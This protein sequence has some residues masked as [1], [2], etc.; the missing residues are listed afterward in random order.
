[1]SMGVMIAA[2]YTVHMLFFRWV[3]ALN[4]RRRHS[5]AV[6]ASTDFVLGGGSSGGDTTATSGS[7]ITVFLSSP[8]CLMTV[9]GLVSGFI[10]IL[11][12]KRYI[13]PTTSL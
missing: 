11:I 4:L 13:P 9:Y 10:M 8:C 12:G 1:M 2:L 6:P 5:V 7:G 3:Q